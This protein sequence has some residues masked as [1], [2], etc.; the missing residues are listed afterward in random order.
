MNIVLKT[1]YSKVLYQDG[2]FLTQRTEGAKESD[3]ERL[4]GRREI[5][6]IPIYFYL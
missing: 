3:R 5:I 6:S 1:N 2:P 4:R